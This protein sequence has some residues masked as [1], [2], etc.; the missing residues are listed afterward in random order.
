MYLRQ[1]LYFPADR[2]F[3]MALAVLPLCGIEKRIAVNPG[4]F[5][6]IADAVIVITKPENVCRTYE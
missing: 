4:G 3:R 6:P 1:T 2:L 5:E